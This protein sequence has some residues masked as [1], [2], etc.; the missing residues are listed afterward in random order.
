MHNSFTRSVAFAL[1]SLFVGGIAGAQTINYQ[2]NSDTPISASGGSAL[3]IDVGS[4][5]GVVTVR[6]WQP[7][8]AGTL[9][10]LDVGKITVRGSWATGGELR[11]LV[12]GTDDD[13][14]VSSLVE[15]S[16]TGV[17]SLGTS[18][19]SGIEIV[20]ANLRAHTR[21]AVFTTDDI[22]GDITVGQV[23]RIQAGGLNPAAATGT[24]SANITAVAINDTFNE[25]EDAVG[26]VK[27]GNAI[28]GNLVAQGNATL[29]NAQN[30]ANYASIRRVVVG[31]ADS[32]AGIQGDIR[33][34]RGS[35]GSVFT[36]GPIGADASGT[37]AARTV[38]IWAGDG[39]VEVLAA[40]EDVPFDDSGLRV[41]KN[42]RMRADIQA[43]RVAYAKNGIIQNEGSLSLVQTNG[44]I[45]G[46]IHAGN[47]GSARLV[48]N[49]SRPAALITSS[50]GQM[51]IYAKGTVQAP[52]TID[53]VVQGNMIAK[54]F[55]QPIVIGRM[56]EGS[57]I[58]YSRLGDGAAS[59]ATL[60]SIRIGLDEPPDAP[61]GV[62]TFAYDGKWG[63]GF[64]GSDPCFT[65]LLSPDPSDPDS[66]NPNVAE[67]FGGI[68]TLCE[69][70]AGPSIIAAN[71]VG[72]IAIS[73]M[74]TWE[75]EAQFSTP[76]GVLTVTPF[77]YSHPHVPL[78]ECQQI[79]SLTIDEFR[80][81]AVWSGVLHNAQL[82]N[83]HPEYAQIGVVNINCMNQGAA[84][85]VKDIGGDS[86]V[87]TTI[88][89]TGDVR[90]AIHMPV[91]SSNASIRIDGSLADATQAEMDPCRY[92]ELAVAGYDPPTQPTDPN[93]PRDTGARDTSLIDIAERGG[94]RGVV[95]INAANAD[96][97]WVGDV[98]VGG[99]TLSPS[100]AYGKSSLYFGGGTVGVV[101]F[102]MYQDDA[103]PMVPP[104][105]TSEPY[106]Y[107]TVPGVSFANADT[108]WATLAVRFYGDVDPTI[109]DGGTTSNMIV[110]PLAMDEQG[111]LVRDAG[112]HPVVAPRTYGSLGPWSIKKQPVVFNEG[113]RRE[114]RVLY[115][116]N[117]AGFPNAPV[118]G[119]YAVVN[120]LY[121]GVTNPPAGQPRYT[122][123]SGAPGSSGTLPLVPDFNW[124]FYVNRASSTSSNCYASRLDFNADGTVNPDDIGD[125]ITA[126]F[127][128]PLLAGPS[129]YAVGCAGNQPPYDDGYQAGYNSNGSGQCNE[130]NPDN[131]GDWITDYFVVQ[132]GC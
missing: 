117:T 35:I 48:I 105:V 15:L 10:A 44:D 68:P 55:T 114:F 112:G 91:L 101:P 11:I 70:G 57:V 1:M 130:P 58:A 92:S 2:V 33:A 20:D 81:G 52:I 84:L 50:T 72:T 122:L 29:F 104:G 113:V 47:I 90:G 14:P 127:T 77:T 42:V 75:S 76:D 23:Q 49:P 53:H 86:P 131:L 98:M 129:G 78:V 56:L 65:S 66:I 39:I 9:P 71:R 7:H 95:T 24:I 13:W 63:Q 19:S 45:V 74:T 82:E 94:L 59:T 41:F 30:R 22:L 97:T 83:T 5:S 4:V 26:Y 73:R 12:A 96:G 64:T 79:D 46:P 85:W 31:P 132:G 34:E 103:F 125:F 36:T 102:R 21:L 108:T 99:E 51:G 87:A 62:A 69:E 89:V 28:T 109:G 18:S 120:D 110:V 119:Y 128:V 106:R 32:A 126:Y 27:A 67:Y 111:N 116:K 123:R 88:H 93:S 121:A 80:E 107:P 17:H 124:V 60:P 37:T 118:A 61:T 38:K 115:Q 16:A 54:A 40:E 43:D 3:A 25:S 8:A 6:V 100:P